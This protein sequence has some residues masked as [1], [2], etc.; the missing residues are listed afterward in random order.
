MNWTEIHYSYCSLS[1]ITDIQ[2][3]HWHVLKPKLEE[4][5]CEAVYVT[6]DSPLMPVHTV[7]VQLFFCFHA[8]NSVPELIE[9]S[10]R[11]LHSQWSILWKELFASSSVCKIEQKED[12]EVY[13][14]LYVRSRLLALNNPLSWKTKRPTDLNKQEYRATVL[15]RLF[16]MRINYKHSCSWHIV[17][18]F[19]G[20]VCKTETVT[21]S[22][23]KESESKSTYCFLIHSLVSQ[24]GLKR[25]CSWEST[26]HVC[27]WR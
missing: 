10:K 23:L 27:K 3:C 14:I 25:G 4:S 26:L 22:N 18:Q 8:D 13:L 6:N 5:T 24:M 7:H 20:W 19:C 17:F 15:K 11:N 2:A 16:P 1:E 12:N 21:E 9:Y